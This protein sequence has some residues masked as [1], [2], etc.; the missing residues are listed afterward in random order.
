MDLDGPQVGSHQGP[1]Q[2]PTSGGSTPQFSISSGVSPQVRFNE[3]RDAPAPMMV[4]AALLQEQMNR[5]DDLTQRYEGGEEAAAPA[6][7][8]AQSPEIGR[9][10]SAPRASTWGALRSLTNR[11]GSLLA[12]MSPLRSSRDSLERQPAHE[13]AA[14]RD[15]APRGALQR[16]AAPEGSPADPAL[17]E[18]TRE[19][20][21]GP[22][23][24]EFGALQEQR[25]AH[26]AEAEGRS[27][28]GPG[29][30]RIVL[31]PDGE[32]FRFAAIPLAS[33]N[34]NEG[35]SRYPSLFSPSNEPVALRGREQTI[36]HLM[37]QQNQLTGQVQEA[38]ARVVSTEHSRNQLQ[39][40]LQHAQRENAMLRDR[41]NAMLQAQG[42]PFAAQ[43][44]PRAGIA[45]GRNVPGAP[46][47]PGMNSSLGPLAEPGGFRPLPMNGGAPQRYPLGEVQPQLMQNPGEGQ[48][49][50][51][52]PVQNPQGQ[53]MNPG[54]PPPRPPQG[55]PPMQQLQNPYPGQ[56]LQQHEH[57][58][59]G[60]P[61]Q[62]PMADTSVR[63]NPVQWG[64]LQAAAPPPL[65]PWGVSPPQPPPGNPPSEI[66][67]AGGYSHQGSA[68]RKEPS[69]LDWVK[70]VGGAFR[71]EQHRRETVEQFQQRFQGRMKISMGK[72]GDS[73]VITDGKQLN[74]M[75]LCLPASMLDAYNRMQ[76]TKPGDI[77][78][79]L[80]WMQDQTEIQVIDDSSW[81]R[82]QLMNRKITQNSSSVTEYIIRFKRECSK[83][84][85]LAEAEKIL[86]FQRG[87]R[88]PFSTECAVDPFDCK[89]KCFADLE[90]HARNV[91][92]K[93]A[94]QRSLAEVFGK[95][96]DGDRKGFQKHS[97]VFRDKSR[98]SREKD[99]HTA[100]EKTAE[101]NA[102]GKHGRNESGGSQNGSQKGSH[103]E[104]FFENANKRCTA[105]GYGHLLNWQFGT[106]VK[107]GRCFICYKQLPMKG[108][109]PKDSPAG[110]NLGAK[111]DSYNKNGPK[112]P[113]PA[114]I[115]SAMP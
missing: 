15:A 34:G 7:A 45:S 27:L 55:E 108:Q 85:D 30:Q 111:C 66:E 58:W 82:M 93:Y 14:L 72:D 104:F 88:E 44:A 102:N 92:L 11:V 38:R 73:P 60:T 100:A 35:L 68:L 61:S 79:L 107:Q 17:R 28:F 96:P 31:T 99:S 39:Q 18:E 6:P 78:T 37:V 10:P 84:S 62:F 71:N 8:L 12:A 74:V 23:G 98:S 109:L 65:N 43:F 36:A 69:L 114:D 3:R 86:H 25:A 76:G 46:P 2:R 26:Q 47:G 70:V 4:P 52:Q 51:L 81:V 54:V 40:A 48:Q 113:W 9:L 56:Q 21:F 24:G 95:V 49:R 112:K 32:P 13:L 91:G 1:P 63:L 110:H 87:L 64:Q 90:K 115:P 80:A 105:K 41:E 22:V 101:K 75:I 29:P 57:T 94:T 67:A 97:R 53:H 103:A 106:L 5:N 16:L 77:P 42:T 33:A 50:Q 59:G 19:F 89:W 83:V 20:S